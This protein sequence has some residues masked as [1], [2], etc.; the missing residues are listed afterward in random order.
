MRKFAKKLK[1]E[2]SVKAKKKS[3]KGLRELGN[4]VR[5]WVISMESIAFYG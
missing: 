4:S 1:S 3:K 5:V 2:G